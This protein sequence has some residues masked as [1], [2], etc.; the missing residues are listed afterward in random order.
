[1]ATRAHNRIDLVFHGQREEKVASGAIKPGH[2]IEV[3]AN[4][5]VKVTSVANVARVKMWA[6]GDHLQGRTIDDAY[7]IGERVFYGICKP[8]DRIL[9]RGLNGQDYTV[10]QLLMP[11]AAG[12]LIAYV[13][14]GTNTPVARV[15]EFLDNTPGS[16]DAFVKVEVL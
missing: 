13:D 9:A 5:K 7:A 10:G 8:G 2:M 14:A 4:D 3:D 12:Q 16:A 11:N 15:V 6:F 1:M